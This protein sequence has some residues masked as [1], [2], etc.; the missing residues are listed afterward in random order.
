M[1]LGLWL[2]AGWAVVAVVAVLWRELRAEAPLRR[3]SAPVAVPA[4]VYAGLVAAQYQYGFA[5]G[6]TSNDPTDRA[7]WTAQ[8][9]A[10]VVVAAGSAW[11]RVRSARMRSELADLVV[12]L[13]AAPRGRAVRD[14]LARA[15][16]EPG[17]VLVYRDVSGAGWIDADGA[18]AERPPGATE[19]MGVAAVGH[20]PGAL[21]DA[22]LVDEI[23]RAALPALEHERLRAQ[24]RAQLAELRASRAR[25]VE[26]G[27]AER[28]R[29]E[30]DLH[31][32]AQQR[33]VALALDVRLA[34]R[35]LARTS[36]GRDDE[37]AAAE[38]DLRLAVAELRKVA[39]GLHPHTLQES[40]LAAA[41]LALGESDPRLLVEELPQ[42]RSPAAAEFAAYQVVAETLRRV[43]DGG[44]VVRGRREG[45]HLVVEVEAD[46]GP[47]T[48]VNL[49]D[50]IGALD[51]RLSVEDGTRTTLRAELP[52][53]S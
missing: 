50:R 47:A 44:V 3:L 30:R 6:F 46:R 43:P 12:E 45:G 4:A 13:D 48:V 16:G 2:V 23:A 36:P 15:L 42:E 5:R 41:L 51:G 19:L 38:D 39:H 52:C 27:D 20:R 25:I 7:L 21:Q 17:L 11:E 9:L 37:L 53:E 31:D 26:T 1:R 18:P 14:A 40:G 49:E 28:R 29:L 35:Q 10:L 33:M 24:L 8:A 34:R 22:R 32:G